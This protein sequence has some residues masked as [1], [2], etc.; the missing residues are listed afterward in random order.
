FIDVVEEC[1]LLPLVEDIAKSNGVE[2]IENLVDDGLYSAITQI[3]TY[4]QECDPI[5]DADQPDDFD[6]QFF[7]RNLPELSEFQPGK[8]SQRS[9]FV[10]LVLDL[11]ETL[12]HSTLERCDD[13]DF[14]FTVSFN[15]EEHTV[16]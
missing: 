10:T 12:V 11:D 3:R 15:M 8:D 4:N 1:L 13:A 2:T 14:T 6:P 9:K 16:Y 5:S 7:I